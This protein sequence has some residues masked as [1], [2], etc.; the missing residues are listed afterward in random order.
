MP[1]IP[2][3][4]QTATSAPVVSTAP[5]LDSLL[6]MSDA[7]FLAIV[8]E[9][10]KALKSQID[11]HTAAAMLGITIRTLQRWHHAN[12]GPKRRRD[13]RGRICYSKTEV[14]AWIAKHGLASAR[15]RAARNTAIGTS[16]A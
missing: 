12:Y 1:V 11:R 8:A 13:L 7:E 9:D 5:S 15:P 6:D 14:E 2:Q 3:K 10:K 4:A 16:I